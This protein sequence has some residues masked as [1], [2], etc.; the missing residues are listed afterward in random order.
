[1]IKSMTGF[2]RAAGLFQDRP[3]TVEMR[4]VNNRYREV[5]VRLPRQYSSLEDEV[6]KVVG[7]R[8]SRGRVEVWIQVNEASDRLKNLKLDLELARTLYG[9]LANLKE[10]LG[11]DCQVSLSDLLEFREIIRYEEEE[12]DLESFL[13]GL[14]PVLVDALDNLVEMRQTE[15]QAISED[16]TGRLDAISGWVDEIESRRT[17]ATEETAARLEARVKALTGDLELDHGR[18]LQEVAYLADRSDI[19][20]EVVR[21]RSHLDQLGALVQRGGVVGRRLDFLLQEIN[22]EVN[23]IGA[24]SGDVSVTNLVVETKAELEKIR[25][26]VQNVE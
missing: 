5:L 17:V 23:T 10:E 16:L 7:R 9:I 4:S 6:K 26:Q 24:K 13:D 14:R 11:L 8:I 18:L 15:G 2:G 20:E 1:M 12:T 25:E 3:L 19:T 21:L 22:R